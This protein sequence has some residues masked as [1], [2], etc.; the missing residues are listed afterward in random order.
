[1]RGLK[2]AARS[3]LH[4]CTAALGGTRIGS[5]LL[6]SALAGA[7]Q[8][9]QSVEHGGMRL[10]FTVPNRLN[11]VRVRTF[12]TK[13]PETLDWIDTIPQGAT[14][15]DIGANVGLYSCYAAKARRCRVIAFEPSVFNVELLARNVALNSLSES[16]TIFPLPLFQTLV[17]STLNMTTTAWGGALSSFGTT[18][19]F[20]GREMAK[21]FEFR[22][23]G[24][25]MDQCVTRLGLPPPQYVKMDVDG[26]EHL[27]LVGG[28][29]TLRGVHS[30]SIEVND[31]FT[32][33]A[34]ECS[35]LLVA[36]G[37]RCVSKAHSQMIDDNPQFNRT[38]NQ[39][40]T[41]D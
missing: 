13:E 38:F 21:V 16:V 8:R 10:Q 2:A 5:V 37:L 19:G 39:V 17:E 41:R 22:T 9:T 18:L 20:D 3:A 11:E 24:L 14:L 33:Q 23:I 30:I 32:A 15:W 4:S 25:A 7:M 1:V 6:E 36:A 34:A 12:A 26:I 29:E 40:W 28:A 35:R 31:A 27:I